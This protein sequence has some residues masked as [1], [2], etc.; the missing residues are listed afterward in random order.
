MLF[1]STPFAIMHRGQTPLWKEI[2]RRDAAFYERLAKSALKLDFGADESGL[3]MKARRSGSGYYSAV[4]ASE[5][6]ARG[7]IKV[8]SGVEIRSAEANSVELTDGSELPAN[9]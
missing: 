7:E 4:G 9:L 8:R 2:R 3:S 1:S 6:I 5:L